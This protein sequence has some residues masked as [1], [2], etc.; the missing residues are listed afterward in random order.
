MDYANPE[1]RRSKKDL[2]RKRRD[3]VYKQGGSKRTVDLPKR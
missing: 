1:R 2:R 3:R